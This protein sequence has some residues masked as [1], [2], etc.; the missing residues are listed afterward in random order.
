MSKAKERE[1]KMFAEWQ[2]EMQENEQHKS[3]ALE[4]EDYSSNEF[5]ANLQALAVSSNLAANVWK[6]L[7]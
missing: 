7:G 4:N 6:V 3:L 2:V 5:H 1:R